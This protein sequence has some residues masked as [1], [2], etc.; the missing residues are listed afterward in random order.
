MPG[1]AGLF[2]MGA[3]AICALPPLNGFFSELLIY[4]GLFTGLQST[5]VFQS[6]SLMLVILALALIGGLALFGFSKAFGITFLGS[7]RSPIHVEEGVVSRGML[8]PKILIG[9]MI[10]FIGFA[11]MLFMSPVIKMLGYQFNMSSAVVLIPLLPV[12]MKIT[13]TGMILVVLIM[14]IVLVRERMKGAKIT[15]GPTWGCGYTAATPRQQYTA[16][17]FSANFAE[18][19]NPM[20]RA[21]DLTEPIGEEDIFPVKRTFTRSY[22]DVFAPGINRVIGWSMLA[23]KKIARLQTGNIQHYILYAFVFMLIIFV[24]LYLGLI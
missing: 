1:T 15:E 2:L 19:A 21:T 17:S 8:F 20:L 23:L 14:L 6:L 5:S 11:P 16:S 9:M 10:F 22:R 24:L 7:P 18:L 3:V 13:I 12:I 4:Y